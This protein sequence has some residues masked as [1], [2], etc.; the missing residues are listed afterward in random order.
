MKVFLFCVLNKD[1]V[2]TKLTNSEMPS[3]KAMDNLMY[4]RT[5]QGSVGE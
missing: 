5:V 1:E 3:S 2:Y 4:K